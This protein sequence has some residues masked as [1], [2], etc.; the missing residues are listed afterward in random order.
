[1]TQKGEII[2][3]RFFKRERNIGIFASNKKTD[4][5]N[6]SQEEQTCD[7]LDDCS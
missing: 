4:E 1:M 5:E 6:D 3:R 2:E 7:E